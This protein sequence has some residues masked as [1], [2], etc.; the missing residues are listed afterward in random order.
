VRGGRASLRLPVTAAAATLLT[1]VCLGEVFVT[2]SWFLPSALAVTAVV[3]AAELTRRSSLPAWFAPVAGLAALLVYLV[4]RYVPGEAFLAVVPDVSAVRALGELV[5]DGNR[6]I[7]RF[8]AP[9]GLTPGIELITVGGVGLVALAV[10]TLAVTLRRAAL[11]GVPLLTLYT[12][13]VSVAPDGVGWPAFALGGAGYL[14][15]LL[16]DAA[17]RLSR[18]GRPV[19]FSREADPTDEVRTAPLSQVGRRVGAAALGLAL[20][21]PAVLPE[22]STGDWGFAGSG[23]G[24]GKGIGNRVAVVNPIVDLGQDLRRDENRSVIQYTGPVTYLRLVSLDLFDGETWRPSQLKVPRDQ[25][26]DRGLPIPPGLSDSVA[27]SRNRYDIQVLDLEQRWLPLPYPAQ[28][29]DIEGRWVYD[30]S[31]FNVFSTNTSTLRKRF[32]ATSLG[33]KLT[34][35]ELRAAPP[36]GAALSRYL[37]LPADIPDVVAETGDKLTER[38]TTAFDAAVALQDFLRDPQEF[39]YSTEAPRGVGD[40]N[41]SAALAAFLRDRRGYCVHFASA[42]AVMARQLGIPARVAVGFTGGTRD[43]DGRQVVSLHDAHSWPELY[44]EGVG[45]V[46]FEP[47]PAARTGTAPAY[48][49]VEDP[50]AVG[51]GP[52]PTT[53]SSAAASPT[54]S[55]RLPEG[56]GA[57]PVSPGS[58]ADARTG[59]ARLRVPAVP[60]AITLVVLLLALVP[61]ATRWA[62]R[63]R[64]WARAG[65][66]E[67]TAAAGW[68]ELHDT[69]VDY[70][71]EWRAS[72]S[73]RG[74]AARLVA[75]QA[76]DPPAA[77]AVHRLA[78]ATERARYATTLGSVGDLRTDVATVAAALRGR[79]SRHRR[80]RA[81]LLPR[82]TRAVSAAVAE[83]CADL[84]DAVDAGVAA[85]RSRLVPRRRAG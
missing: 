19:R 44:F 39:T 34:P 70:G 56:A 28:R 61:T 42:M 12:V 84:L 26:L 14:A 10:D 71:C 1:A 62:V 20:V 63:R 5:R 11:A 81:R 24:R 31:T 68:D 54:P 85:A 66:P 9:V 40:G 25:T 45:W 17:E 76:L 16:G 72:D 82:S 57:Q 64:R 80:L 55:S 22:I 77:E 50:T 35:E 79:A 13:P 7:A 27:R 37:K 43:R 47:T 15:L 21:V 32:T 23:F 6:D 58:A 60:A 18:W 30:R 75:E 3:G 48:T 36:A 59:W 78:T 51:A 4:A 65:T 69:L 38:A 74:L 67:A 33:V 29:V 41:G 8:A 46:A 52:Q 53:G 49:R 83:R 2:G 73:P